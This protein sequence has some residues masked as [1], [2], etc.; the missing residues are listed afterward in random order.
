MAAPA[1]RWRRPGAGKLID[2][3]GLQGLLDETARLAQDSL[4]SD[5]FVIAR[6]LD[7]TP[8]LA[9]EAAQAKRARR[10]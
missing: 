7:P 9:S 2:R 5:A 8:R 1:K 10:K 3:H 4:G 6:M